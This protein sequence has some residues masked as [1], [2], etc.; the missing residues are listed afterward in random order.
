MTL[1]QKVIKN[2]KI[3][4]SL[5]TRLIPYE[6]FNRSIYFYYNRHS[7]I[8]RHRRIKG[9][10]KSSLNIK[11]VFFSLPSTKWYRPPYFRCP[12]IEHARK[13]LQDEIARETEHPQLI[14]MDSG[15][16]DLTSTAPI[17][18]SIPDISVSITQASTVFS[19]STST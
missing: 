2:N 18:G 19:C 8:C 16:N 14:V 4:G 15:T 12:K 10:Q 11:G 17:D 7:R 6:R 9:K 5:L 3:R 1:L 13:I